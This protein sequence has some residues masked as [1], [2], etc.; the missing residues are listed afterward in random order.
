MM[1]LLPT[2]P[3]WPRWV[4]VIQRL[5]SPMRVGSAV[6]PRCTVVPSRKTLRLPMTQPAPAFC[7]SKPM[8]CGAKPRETFG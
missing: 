6:L 2:T 5:P 3:S 4:F 8:S 1:Q 7:G